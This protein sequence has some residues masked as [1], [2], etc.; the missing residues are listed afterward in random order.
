MTL[1]D[2]IVLI[3]VIVL[4]GIWFG[5]Y[6]YRTFSRKCGST[7]CSNCSGCSRSKKKDL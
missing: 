1:F 4:L 5:R 6:L 7:G 3:V 2:W